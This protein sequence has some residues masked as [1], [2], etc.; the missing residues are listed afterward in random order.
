MTNGMRNR[1]SRT[2]ERVDARLAEIENNLL[3]GTTL[4]WDSIRPDLAD[5]AEYDRLRE[6]VD[7]STQRNESIG[8]FVDRLKA[9]G[10]GGMALLERVKTFMVA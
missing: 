4:D 10:E 6:I 7:E 3:A 1:A 8:Q 5:R 9:L 2:R